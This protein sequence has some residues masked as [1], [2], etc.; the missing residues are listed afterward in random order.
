MRHLERRA[1]GAARRACPT[2]GRRAVEEID[3]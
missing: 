1:S 2:L 3:G